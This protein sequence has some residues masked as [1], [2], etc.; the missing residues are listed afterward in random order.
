[1]ESKH[2][3]LGPPLGLRPRLPLRP[4]A[5]R[6]AGGRGCSRGTSRGCTSR[7]TSHLS[8][9]SGG[10][11]SAHPQHSGHSTPRGPG[12]GEPRRARFCCPSAPPA[13]LRCAAEGPPLSP[14]CLP[15]P[16]GDHGLAAPPPPRTHPPR[17]DDHPAHLRRRR[18]RG[19]A[20]TG[21]LVAAPL[22]PPLSRMAPPLARS[23]AAPAL[24]SPAEPPPPLATRRPLRAAPLRPPRLRPLHPP[25]GCVVH[26]RARRVRQL[27]PLRL[28]PP[29]LPPPPRPLRPPRHR[30]LLRRWRRVAAP[31]AA[32]ASADLAA[33][34]ARSASRC[35]AA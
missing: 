5:P 35:L 18:R 4:R 27:A 21:L 9:G 6:L 22:G 32:A 1:M 30:P 3:A 11:C 28:R 20:R 19:R 14:P 29:R 31:A 8:R 24:R 7:G 15:A 10:T 12:G 26:A 23:P 16:G 25:H 13:P 2:V 33:R 34:P 17:K